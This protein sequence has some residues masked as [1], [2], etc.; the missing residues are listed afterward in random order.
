MNS[1]STAPTPVLGY[2]PGLDGLRAVAVLAVMA[3]HADFSWALGGYLGVDTFFVLSGFLITTLLHREWL[4]HQGHGF[5]TINL[6][7]FYMRRTLR[8]LPALLLL[9]VVLNIYSLWWVW[10]PHQGEA[11]RRETVAAQ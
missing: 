8:L 9:V 6:G 3:F 5:E 1:Q 11:L 2:Q 10:F 4:H 7:R